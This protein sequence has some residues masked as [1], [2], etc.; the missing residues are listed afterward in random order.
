MRRASEREELSAA[1][2]AVH[3]AALL[4]AVFYAPIVWGQVSIPETH[5]MGNISSSAG[6]ALMTGLIGL[7]ALGALAAR[8]LSGQGLRRLPNAVHAPTLALL[9]V[10][11]VSTLFS[12]NPHASKIELARLAIG[13]LFFLLVANRALLPTSRASVVAVAFACSIVLTA[14][15]PMPGESGL[16]L[17]LFAAIA[18]GIG[19]GLIVSQRDNPDPTGW[20]RAALILSA[21][22]V[23][24]AYGWREKVA[25]A[26]DLENPTWAIFSTFFNPNPLGG[27]LAMVCPLALGSAL[28]SSL[29]ARRILWGFCAFVLAATILPTYSKGAMATLAVGLLAFLVLLARQR[30]TAARL[31]RILLSLAVAALLVFALVAWQSDAIRGR[32]TAT[33]GPESTS[34]MFRIFTWRGTIRMA[35]AYAVTG[36][37]PAAFKYAYPKYAT[38]G[39]VEASH[40]DYL[41]MFAE[42]GVV[43]GMVFLWLIAAVLA[44]GKRALSS[45][46]DFREQALTIGAICCI[47]SLTFNSL[48]DYGWYMGA[49]NLTFWLAAGILVYQAHGRAHATLPQADDARTR[50]RRA[51]AREM[52]ALGLLAAMMG[53]CIA[54]ALSLLVTVRSALAQRAVARGDATATLS[55]GSPEEQRNALYLSLAQYDK[56]RAY[57]PKWAD[58]WERYAFILASVQGPDPA[59]DIL[60]HAATLRP[61]SFRPF[62]TMGRI[63]QSYSRYD[64]AVDAFRRALALYPNHTKSLGQLAEVYKRMGDHEKALETYRELATLE[65]APYGRYR[66]LADMDVDTNFAF[67]HYELGW[68]AQRAFADGQVDAAER[69]L[70]EYQAA[71]QIITEYYEKA[72]QYDTM[73]KAFGRPK[74]HRGEATRM[75]EAKVRW[76]MG[77]LHAAAGR[78][79]QARGERERALALWPNAQREIELEDAS[80]GQ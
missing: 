20:W 3:D 30:G 51:P 47:V 70:E 61:T 40:Q 31:A 26:R 41:Q 69:A 54:V 28:A 67:A 4:I 35:Q 77:E 66:A 43:G 72:E 68:T 2:L 55:G 71:F 46:T 56:A 29:P 50:R 64:E 15:T 59:I 23:V 38:T 6:Q 5:S 58:A 79:D 63:Y 1:A 25:V 78:E 18:V 12:V 13:A 53:V 9:V 80:I 45:Q 62:F 65:T 39:Y 49:T 10:A 52:Q 76:R 34:N 75:L 16:A 17:R 7:A 57:D 14:F 37:G 32:I 11:A 44:T 36:I 60:K 42:L 8:W 73:F 19:V 74:Q 33:L 24:S 22:L 27:F 48:L 21:T